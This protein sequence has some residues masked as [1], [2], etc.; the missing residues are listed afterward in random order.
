MLR[1]KTKHYPYPGKQ[2][3]GHE[4]DDTQGQG[5]YMKEELT[6]E[7]VIFVFEQPISKNKQPNDK[8]NPHNVV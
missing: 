5:K 8:N 7:E 6:L 2:N 3:T 4:K 1:W